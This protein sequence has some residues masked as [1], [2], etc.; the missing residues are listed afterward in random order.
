MKKENKPTNQVLITV[1]TTKF[2]ELIK[3]IDSVDFYNE[4]DKQ[5][6]K[7]LIIQKGNGEYIPVNYK[8]CKFNYLVVDVHEYLNGF[9]KIIQNSDLVIS[10]CGA[11]TA[12]ETFKYKKTFI[13]TVNTKLMDNHQTEL[14]EQL[15]KEK[16][17]YFAETKDI[18]ELIVKYVKGECE[19]IK[20][21]PEFDYNSIP[22]IIYDM[23]GV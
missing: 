15:V 16:Y 14:A 20:I 6:V 11:G 22:N 7:K 13:A 12:L 10:H 17:I 2:D 21:Y 5:C 9:E 19:S 4:L 8:Q 1:G 18:K 23:M 3:N